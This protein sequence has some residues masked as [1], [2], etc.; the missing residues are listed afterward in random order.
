LR[1]GAIDIQPVIDGSIVSRLPASKP[2]P[3]QDSA[4]WQQQHGMF[5]AGGLIESTVGA[6]LIRA[7][8]RVILVDAGAGQAFP[9]GYHPVIIDVDDPD[10]PLATAYLARGLSEE[11]VRQYA[12]DFALI[13][14]TQGALPASLAAT[15]TRPDEVTDVVLTHLHFD[16]IGWVSADGEPYFPNATIRC[17]AADL[18]YFLPGPAEERTVSLIYNAMR[19][20][21]RLE[22]VL[23]RIETWDRDEVLMPCINV[24]LAPGHTPGSSVVVVS[25]CGERAMLLGDVV[26]CPLELMDNDFDLI[27][28]HDA[29][30]AQQAR[31]AYAK[32][33]E[34]GETL[35]AAAHFPGLKFG[36]LLAGGGTRAW[37]FV[38]GSH[39]G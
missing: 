10:D 18:D 21:E 15:G 12:A 20:P 24:R 8:G 26:H 22:P 36:R 33:L 38:E 39:I 6:F 34:D 30:L 11:L 29:Q 9:D 5:R 16:H 35:V 19:A 23:D 2:L 14:V 27:A 3:D 37:A 7:H 28:D 31:E 17:A 32:E 13:N 25:D 4:L 1:I